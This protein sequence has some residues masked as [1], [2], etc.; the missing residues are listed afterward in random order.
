MRS[1]KLVNERHDRTLEA[2]LE[3][4]GYRT[5]RLEKYTGGH[6]F[7]GDEFVKALAWFLEDT[8]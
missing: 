2:G 5:V 8:E 4:G 3:G 7:P 1:D 6:R